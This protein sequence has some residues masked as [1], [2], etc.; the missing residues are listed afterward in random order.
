MV[1]VGSHLAGLQHRPGEGEQPADDQEGA[2]CGTGPSGQRDRR[3]DEGG[4]EGVEGQQHADPAL[5][6]GV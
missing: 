6:S 5:A 2:F 4:E 1:G 3:R